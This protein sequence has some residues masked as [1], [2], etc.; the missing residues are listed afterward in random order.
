MNANKVFSA[1]V[2]LLALVSLSFLT[3]CDSV[4]LIQAKAA[5]PEEIANKPL[6]TQLDPGEIAAFRWIAMARAY[7]KMELFNK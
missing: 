6:L 5:G 1:L 4:G 7:E 2:I 3:A